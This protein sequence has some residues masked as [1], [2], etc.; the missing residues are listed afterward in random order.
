VYTWLARPFRRR[1]PRPVRWLSV[2]FAL[3]VNA[4]P[5]YGVLAEGWS[6][7]TILALYWLENL[8]T[9]VATCL[10]IA[11]HRSWTGK[12]GHY[13][14]GQLGVVAGKSRPPGRTFLAEYATAALVF[15]LAHGVFVVFLTLIL[16]ENHPGDRR[17]QLSLAQLRFGA[18][19]VASFLGAGLV[20]DLPSLPTWSFA[21]VRAYAQQRLG[22]VLIL[23]LTIIF[24]M[25]AIMLTESPFGLLFVLIGL[26]TLADV[27]GAFPHDEPLPDKPP[28]W[29]SRFVA[30]VGP[31]A[32][33]A[34]ADF[35]ADWRRE[36]ETAR[37][38]AQEDEERR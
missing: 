5:V 25:L 8:L 37:R 6:A 9:A 27:A 16:A 10:R 14:S 36:I 38:Q 31:A 1:Y 35:D 15:T 18:A 29:A 4:V 28:A 23:H 22:R 24:G 13:R 26:K 32:G 17:W 2:L 11:V 34:G 3:L 7:A 33:H 19:V 12:R 30:R 20:V 21:R